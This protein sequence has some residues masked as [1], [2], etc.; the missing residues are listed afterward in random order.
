M[1]IPLPECYPGLPKIPFLYVAEAL[2]VQQ[3]TY[4]A[5]AFIWHA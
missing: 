2:D 1:D 5:I 4:T 3:E